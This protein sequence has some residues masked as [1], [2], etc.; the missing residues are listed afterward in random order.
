MEMY[1]LLY[2][3]KMWYSSSFDVGGLSGL[4]HIDARTEMFSLL[5]VT[6][7]KRENLSIVI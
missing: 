4:T 2:V 3:K 6:S 1:S 5:Y 7:W